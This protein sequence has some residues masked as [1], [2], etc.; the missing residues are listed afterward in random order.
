MTTTQTTNARTTHSLDGTISM[1]S[2]ISEEDGRRDGQARED[3]IVIWY[4]QK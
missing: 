2:I 1:K 3:C 4:G